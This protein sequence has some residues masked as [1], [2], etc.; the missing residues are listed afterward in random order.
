MVIQIIDIDSIPIFKAKNETP[1]TPH[2]NC[3][4]TG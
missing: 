3:P 4:T 1:V 2:R